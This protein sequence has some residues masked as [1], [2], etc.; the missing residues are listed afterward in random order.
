MIAFAL[1]LVV[2]GARFVGDDVA[3]AVDHR[4]IP[5]GGHADG[6]GKDGRVAGARYAVQSLVP[7]LVVGNAEARNGGG[8]VFK[9]RGLL[10]ERHAADQ[11]VGA[12]LRRKARI[13]VSRLLCVS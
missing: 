4:R 8:P 10:F 6:L 3:H 9:L 11:V 1:C 12:F 7:G 5:R 13:Q 2:L